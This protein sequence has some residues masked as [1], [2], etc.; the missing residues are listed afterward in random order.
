MVK[1]EIHILAFL[2]IDY[3]VSVVIGHG[4]GVVL[5]FDGGYG[6]S[7]DQAFEH[8]TLSI[9]LLTNCGFFQERWSKSINLSVQRSGKSLIFLLDIDSKSDCAKMTQKP[10]KEKTFSCKKIM[11]LLRSQRLPFEY[12]RY[13]LNNLYKRVR[14]HGNENSNHELDIRHDCVVLINHK[15]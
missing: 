5:P 2:L 13:I 11:L 8:K 10:N 15:M 14:K 6:I 7:L 1:V 3:L 12:L 9:I 4:T